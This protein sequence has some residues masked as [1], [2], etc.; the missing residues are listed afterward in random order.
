MKNQYF[1]QV[2]M[3]QLLISLV[4]AINRM[5]WDSMIYHI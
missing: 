1:T 3:A 2:I 5:I 4:F